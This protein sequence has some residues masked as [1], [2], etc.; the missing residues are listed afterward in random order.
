MGELNSI[1]LQF[2]VLAIFSKY[3]EEFVLYLRVG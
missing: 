3:Y 2:D 1:S